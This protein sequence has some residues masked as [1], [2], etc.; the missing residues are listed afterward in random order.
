MS[1]RGRFVFRAATVSAILLS[2]AAGCGAKPAGP[3]V[4]GM[5]LPDAKAAL[6]KAGVNASVHATDAI[7]GVLVEDNFVVC[8]EDAINQH[9]VRLEVAKHGC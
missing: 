8:D 5:S 2:L 7:F 6:K 4:R 1:G 3:D 9:M